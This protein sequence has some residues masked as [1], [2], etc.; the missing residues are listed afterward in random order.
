MI[1]VVFWCCLLAL[2]FGTGLVIDRS[3]DDVVIIDRSTDDVVIIDRSTDGAWWCRG[4]RVREN[5][6]RQPVTGLARRGVSLRQR[7]ASLGRWPT[8]QENPGS[9]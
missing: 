9:L 3:T 8:D 1:L 6:V 7:H 2:V 4:T 5:K